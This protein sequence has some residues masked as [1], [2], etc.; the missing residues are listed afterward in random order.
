MHLKIVLFDYQAGPDDI[1][2][3]VFTDHCVAPLNKRHQQ[4]KSARTEPCWLSIYLHLS[5]GALD[6]K[7]AKSQVIDCVAGGRDT[8]RKHA[9]LGSRGFVLVYVTVVN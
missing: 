5:G 3:F 8:R 4:I 7:V 1:E 9:I 2:E 6:D